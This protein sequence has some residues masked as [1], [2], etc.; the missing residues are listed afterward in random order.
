M[1]HR[2]RA[3]GNLFAAAQSGSRRYFRQAN[4]GLFESARAFTLQEYAGDSSEE[5]EPERDRL[6]EAVIRAV[7]EAIE[8]LGG[9][10]E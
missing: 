1:I 3:A 9:T 5:D 7:E 6:R 4:L 8:R 2:K 10:T